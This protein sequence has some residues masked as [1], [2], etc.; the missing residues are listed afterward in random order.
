M[1]EG[2]PDTSFGGDGIVITTFST[3]AEAYAVVQQPD[4]KLV[5]AGIQGGNFALIRYTTDGSLDSTFGIGGI[6]AINFGADEYGKALALQTDGKLIIAGQ[7]DGN[8]ALARYDTNGLPDLTFGGGGLVITSLDGFAEIHAIVL[9][10]DGKPVAAGFVDHNFALAR[11]NTDGSLDAAFNS[12]GILVTDLG[13]YD[14]ANDLAL[15]PDGKLIAAGDTYIN[16]DY[17]F[18]LVRYNPDGSLDVNFGVS[19]TITSAFSG[20]YDDLVDAIVLLPDGKV[21]AA[22]SS[23]NDTNMD[24]AL[25]RFTPNGILD[26]AFGRGGH[27][28]TNLS[29]LN[30]WANAVAV[31]PD[32]KMVV[33]GSSAELYLTGIGYST[34]ARY[35]P[36]GSLDTSFDANGLWFSDIQQLLYH[37]TALALLPDGKIAIAGDNFN[38]WFLERL[39]TNGTLDT[40]FG[41][42]GQVFLDLDY[43]AEA[44]AL[45]LQPD[46][47]L[48]IA[49]GGNNDFILARYNPNGTL[50]ADFGLGGLVTTTI[51]LSSQGTALIWQ[52]DGKLILAGAANGNYALARYNPDGSLDTYFGNNGIV[53]TDFGGDDEAMALVLL[54]DGK[55]AA[56]GSSG[57]NFALARYNADGLLDSTFGVGG[58]VTADFGGQEAGRA[59]NWQLDGTLLLAGTADGDFALA[60]FA[61]D[62]TLDLS[63]G[64]NGLLR[65][66]LGGDETLVGMARQPDGKLVL[67]G[68]TDC[69]GDTDFALVRYLGAN[70]ESFDYDPNGQFEWLGVGEQAIDT[71][72][73]TIADPHGLTAS[74]T[75]SITITGA[76]DAPVAHDLGIETARNTAYHGTLTAEDIDSDLLTYTP[77]LT[78]LYGTLELA[79]SGLFTF[80]PASDYVGS[81]SFTYTVTDGDLSASGSV[82]ITVIEAFTVNSGPDQ[83]GREGDWLAFVG[84]YIDPGHDATAIRWDFGDGTTI[85]GT[86]IPIHA[87]GDEGRY[88][89]TLTI[90][91]D[92]GS[93]GWDMLA[94]TVTNVAP[95]LAPLGPQSGFEGAPLTVTVTFTDPGWLDAHSVVIDWGDGTTETVQLAAGEQAIDLGHTYAAPGDYTVHLTVTD[96][97]GG[98]DSLD[99]AIHV[100]AKFKLFLPLVVKQPFQ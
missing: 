5:V 74:A 60:R 81:D 71:F 83:T 19:G 41:S 4:G 78:P 88:L 77:G 62:G 66:D 38:R 17:D 22:G 30:D 98:A 42:G 96:D 6:V 48:V 44:R 90:T 82:S 12:T 25:A 33:V 100:A 67:A 15:Q 69:N 3:S 23:Y 43:H 72:T 92:V 89:V 32:G 94:V 35:N 55:L 87:Y 52:P 54:P 39:N 75:V 99:L 26:S 14:H 34:L 65:T 2:V 46:G 53:I 13:G 31:Q 37:P 70:P 93:V 1:P 49:G 59:L 79:A 95:A 56:A 80:T 40:E 86:L 29:G 45:L 73:Y 50:D 18:A 51:G 9:Q 63:L 58:L 24:F 47:K 76:N 7:R 28:T 10:P 97:D 36:D 68:T 21:V 91:D 20:G 57:T 8:F 27:V 84:T 64:S 11:Y 85:S 61:A 16:G